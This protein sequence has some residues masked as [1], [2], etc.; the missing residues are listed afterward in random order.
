MF[1]FLKNLFGT[2]LTRQKL[3]RLIQWYIIDQKPP[4]G[5]FPAFSGE[6]FL[7]YWG[8]ERL[9]LT[10]RDPEGVKQGHAASSS[11]NKLKKLSQ[12]RPESRLR[13]LLINIMLYW[14]YG[15]VTCLV[16][17]KLFLVTNKL[18]LVTNKLFIG[19]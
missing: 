18:F 15:D 8:Y 16:T 17:N 11:L 2:S 13:R 7:V 12:K 10:L 1:S 14:I 19:H 5:D 9:N 6:I 3:Y 4:R